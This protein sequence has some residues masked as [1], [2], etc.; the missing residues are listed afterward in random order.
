MDL[1]ENLMVL[2]LG[3]LRVIETQTEKVQH[4]L[5]PVLSLPLHCSV[6]LYNV[7]HAVAASEGVLQRDR[8]AVSPILCMCSICETL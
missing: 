1:F 6:L 5:T 2:I 3:A 4:C 7:L 8:R